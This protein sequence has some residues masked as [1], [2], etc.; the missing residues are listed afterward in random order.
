MKTVKI[1][2]LFVLAIIIAS[3]LLEAQESKVLIFSKTK[4]FRHKSVEHGRTV[5]AE[6]CKS[7]NIAVDSTEDAELFTSSNLKQYDA[8]IFLN[9]TGDLFNEKQQ[10]ALA[11]YINNGGGFVG[12]HAA[13][14]AEYDWVWYRGNDWRIL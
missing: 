12:I 11:K 10:K 1:F 6:M 9:T 3:P 4:G 13:T 14:D 7:N 2:L 5:I 8:L